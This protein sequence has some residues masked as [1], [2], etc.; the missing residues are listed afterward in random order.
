MTSGVAESPATRAVPADADPPF[1]DESHTTHDHDGEPGWA[2][3]LARATAWALLAVL[4][5]HVVTEL[6]LRD[7]A[8]VTAASQLRRW[9]DP[10]WR[11]LDWL[12]VVI[13]C[14]HVAAAVWVR[15]QP[16]DGPGS[17]PG[18][19]AGLAVVSLCVVASLT[20]TMVVVTA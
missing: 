18:L 11:V 6:V 9:D 2:S 19:V 15:A 17:K 12:L 7:P 13:G 16:A 4:P 3:S 8:G 1:G 14:L 20:M 5:V 10:A